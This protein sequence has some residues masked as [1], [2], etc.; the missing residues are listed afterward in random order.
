MDTQ[1]VHRL[2]RRQ[3]RLVIVGGGF[4]GVLALLVSV[5]QSPIYQAS[6]TVLPC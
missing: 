6:T 4:V 2:V 1:F 5:F 3:W